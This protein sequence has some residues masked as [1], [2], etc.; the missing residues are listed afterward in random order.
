MKRLL[1]LGLTLSASSAFAA[2]PVLLETPVTYAPDASVIKQVRDECH[3]EDLLTHRV[4]D[5]LRRNNRKGNG[6]LA[7]EADAADATTLRLQI[8]NVFG[9]GGGAWSGPK[10]LTVSADL[11]EGGKVVRHTTV[12]RWSI[13]GIWGGFKG[14]CSILDRTAIFISKDL[15]R[16][17]RDPS[18]VIKE[19]APPAEASAPAAQSAPESAETA[20]PAAKPE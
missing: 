19:E 18:Y 4:G 12:K 11:L 13:G 14:T 9:V 17:V 6:L 1:L 5:V 16:W 3:I 7:S 10:A 15:G 20:E 2:N 8:M